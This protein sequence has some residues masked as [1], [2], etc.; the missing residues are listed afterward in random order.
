MK[1]ELGE[2]YF[3][4]IVKVDIENEWKYHIAKS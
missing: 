3:F 4:K 1:F 2:Y